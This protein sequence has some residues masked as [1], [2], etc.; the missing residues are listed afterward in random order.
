LAKNTAKKGNTG[1]FRGY[2]NYELSKAEKED[3]KGKDFSLE[4][5][6]GYIE[7]MNADS[8][9][10]KFA[11]DYYNRCFQCVLGVNDPKH[12]NYGIFLSG[13]GS[14]PTKALKQAMY[15]HH[16]ICQKQWGDWLNKPT[17]EEMD[18]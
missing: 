10:V 18:D 6:A 15:I 16:T 3:L 17:A 1:D 11:Y 2:V 4:A 13:R 12:E 5:F 9:T 7:A 8:Y 14:S